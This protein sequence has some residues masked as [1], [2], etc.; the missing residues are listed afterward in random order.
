MAET[1]TTLKDSASTASFEW[2]SDAG[3]ETGTLIDV[4]SLSGAGDEDNQTVTVTRIEATVVN[5]DPMAASYVT[6]SWG[7]GTDAIYLPP[8]VHEIET[9]LNPS[10]AGGANAD[11]IV[12]VEATTLAF[13]RVYVAK[14]T[15]FPLSM[16]HSRFRP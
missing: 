14:R 4:S 9:P 15:G 3:S 12:D 5:T 16:G 13:L 11:L 8:G 2:V 10:S 6:L 1:I 7:D